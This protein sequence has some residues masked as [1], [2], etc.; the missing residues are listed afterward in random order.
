[1]E[2]TKQVQSYFFV[3]YLIPYNKPQKKY[4]NFQI[5]EDIL[6]DSTLRLSINDYIFKKSKGGFL[7]PNNGAYLKNHEIHLANH[8]RCTAIAGAKRR[9]FAAVVVVGGTLRDGC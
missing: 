2:R 5:I 7:F 6:K 4:G 3:A 9:A 8:G 1:M